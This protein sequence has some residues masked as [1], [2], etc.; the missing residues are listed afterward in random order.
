M[1]GDH[2]FGSTSH[3]FNAYRCLLNFYARPP[4]PV[5][6]LR[7]LKYCILCPFLATMGDGF[8][9]PNPAVERGRPRGRPRENPRCWL[10]RSA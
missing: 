5:E 9:L 2:A 10:K 1:C 3:I 8:H 4:L 6:P 7:A